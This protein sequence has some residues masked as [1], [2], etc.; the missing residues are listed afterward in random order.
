[1]S[2]L[3]KNK[4]KNMISNEEIKWKLMNQKLHMNLKTNNKNLKLKKFKNKN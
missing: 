4:Y 2:L 1:M 3:M